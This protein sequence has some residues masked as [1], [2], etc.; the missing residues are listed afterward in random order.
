MEKRVYGQDELVTMKNIMDLVVAMANKGHE[1]DK[2][3]K[4]AGVIVDQKMNIIAKS[5]DG[6]HHNELDHATMCLINEAAG[7]GD[8]ILTGLDGSLLNFFLYL[9]SILVYIYREPCI[10]CSMA[11]SHSRVRTVFYLEP[12][13]LNGA[14]GSKEE[15]HARPE[16]NHRLVALVSNY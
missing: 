6:R 2:C 8:Y 4:Q 9:T 16:L 15:I 3:V 5:G 13:G 1:R 11:L 12:D 10:M 14:L 7:L